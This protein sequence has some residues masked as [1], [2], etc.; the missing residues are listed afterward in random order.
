MGWD[1]T[2][3]S[4]VGLT[5]LNIDSEGRGSGT[6]VSTLHALLMPDSRLRV[7]WRA[8][9]G[10]GSIA[11]DAVRMRVYTMRVWQYWFHCTHSLVRNQG[12]CVKY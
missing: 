2:G 9:H 1:T 8:P 6:R 10:C 12:Q 3:A 5:W 7:S 11:V 4:D